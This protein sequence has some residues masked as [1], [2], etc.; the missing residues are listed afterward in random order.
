MRTTE[1]PNPSMK[2]SRARARGRDLLVEKRRTKVRD[3]F[4]VTMKQQIFR[5]ERCGMSL[6]KSARDVV[7]HRR[8][9]FAQRPILGKRY[10][11][12]LAPSAEAKPSEAAR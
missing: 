10:L 8:I 12:P 2:S 1:R 4:P 7:L 6:A 5:S 9:S 3:A 11:S